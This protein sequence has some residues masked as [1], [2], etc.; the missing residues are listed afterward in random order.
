MKRK[1]E[2]S[3]PRRL[4]PLVSNS[5]RPRGI[6]PSLPSGMDRVIKTYFDHYRGSLPPELVGEVEGK[7]IPIDVLRQQLR[8]QLS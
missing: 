4:F 5:P 7:L 8:S 3:K 2:G 1:N 6:F